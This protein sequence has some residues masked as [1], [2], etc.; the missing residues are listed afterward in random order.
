M[1][2]HKQTYK[3]GNLFVVFK[4]KF[5]T[6][7]NKAQMQKINEALA[8]QKKKGDV[9]MEVAETC[10][11]IEFKE[12]HRN[13]HHEGGQEGNGGSDEENDDDPRGGHKVRCQQQ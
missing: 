1:P 13:T 2:Y 9:D 10:Q 7:L 4:I 11:L 5:P 3:F 8:F 12:H 6:E